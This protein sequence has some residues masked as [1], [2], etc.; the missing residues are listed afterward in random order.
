M[1]NRE[2]ILV[3]S[4]ESLHRQ[5]FLADR[6]SSQLPCLAKERRKAKKNHS[7]TK[8]HKKYDEKKIKHQKGREKFIPVH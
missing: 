8:R 1:S 4:F 7:K 3:L 2:S 5:C 6:I